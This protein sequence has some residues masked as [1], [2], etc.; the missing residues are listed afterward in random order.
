[1][2]DGGKIT[3]AVN[4]DKVQS[5]V[6]KLWRLVNNQPGISKSQK[7]AIKSLY[8][9]VVRSLGRSA[10]PTPRS[11]TRSRRSSSQ[12]LRPNV[13]EP[14]SVQE[15]KLP[16]LHLKRKSGQSWAYSQKLTNIYFDV[17]TEIATA[18]TTFAKKAALMTGVGKGSIG[19]EVLK[20]LLA[21]GA[22]VVVTT[23]RYSREAVDYY[24]DVFHQFGSRGSKLVVVPFNGASKQ[25]VEALVEYIYS[26][27]AIDLDYIIPFAALPE[28]GREIDGIDDRSELAHRLMLVNVLRLMGAVKTKKASRNFVTRPTQVVLPLSPNHGL[29]GND[30]LYSESKIG[31]ETLFNRWSAESWGEYLCIAG[32]VIGWT[33]GTGLMSATNIVA[34]GIEKMGVRTF[35]AKEMAFNILGLMHPLLFNITQIEPIWA[36]LGGGMDRLPDLADVTTKVRSDLNS[37]A[38][39]RRAITMENSADFKVIN[40]ADAE[41]LHQKVTIAPRANFQFDFPALE[42]KDTLKELSHLQGLIDLEKVVVVTGFSEVGPWGS[43]RTRWEMEARG[44]F[45]IEGCIEMAWMM[46]FIKHFDGKLKDGKTYVGWVDAKSGEP[47]DDKDIRAKYEKEIIAHTGIRIIGKQCL[48]A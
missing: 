14:T 3:N 36:D 17:L 28:N 41:R 22:T 23:S 35:S 21:G 5:D 32:A 2:A 19:V 30:G 12:F 20:G 16:F 26:T 27:L 42:S 40:G 11:A 46:G 31:L 33:R 29:F 4:L 48:S 15:S 43:S 47:V 25:D 13:P 1:M 8:G 24:K 34:E 38:A 9:D 6:A 44:Q 18:G 45:T 10:E 39:L 7:A 37:T